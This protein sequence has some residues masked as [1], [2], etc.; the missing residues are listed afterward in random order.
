MKTITLIAAS[1]LTVGLGGCAK[2][3][4]TVDGNLISN[5]EGSATVTEHTLKDGT[6]CVVLIGYYKGAIS[7]DWR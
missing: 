5:G 3:E 6:R 4:A 2:T 1:L 7:C